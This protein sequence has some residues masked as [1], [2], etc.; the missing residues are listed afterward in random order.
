NSVG[1]VAMVSVVAQLQLPLIGD[2]SG[3]PLKAWNEWVVR[4]NPVNSTGTP[5]LLRKV[6]AKAGIKK[7]AVIFD[8]TQ[9]SQRSDAEITKA[10]ADAI[11]YQVVAY[12]AF[13]TGEPDF[14]AQISTIRGARPDAIFVAAAV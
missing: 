1:F 13:R 12:E 2:G 6:T 10:Q 11:G 7:M 3:V 14:S 9:D 4:I 5:V 8:Q